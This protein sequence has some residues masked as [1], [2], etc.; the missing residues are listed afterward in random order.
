MNYRYVGHKAVGSEM[1]ETC[2][3]N[4]DRLQQVLRPSGVYAIQL[5]YVCIG[6]PG[7]WKLCVPVDHARQGYADWNNQARFK[8]NH[9]GL[10]FGSI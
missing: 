10:K 5:I 4:A 8:Y 1:H 7:N 3:G 6:N 9:D 2:L